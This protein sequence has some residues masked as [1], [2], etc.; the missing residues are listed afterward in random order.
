MSAAL[1]GAILAAGRGTR[2]GPFSERY[3]KPL[4]PVCN[5]PLIQH[6]IALMRS[7][8]VEEIFVL[9]GHRGY[10]IVRVLG[11]GSQLGVRIHY[12]EQS[13]M[14]GIAHAVGCLEPHLDRP[15]LLSL[16]DIFFV[17][18]DLGEMQ[19]LL[20][21]QGGGGVLA[22]RNETDPDAV[23]RNFTVQLSDDGYVRRVIEKPRHPTT[24][25][26]GV[27]LYLFDP[28]IFD[29]IRRTPRTALRDEYEL[30]ES[31]QVMIDDGRPVRV[32]HVVHEDINVTTPADLLRCNL[33]QARR[34]PRGMLVGRDTWIH[35][36]AQIVN[37]VIGSR[38]RIE[39]AV[40]IANSV[41]FDDCH[42][43]TETWL[44]TVVVTP[45]LVVECKHSLA[46]PS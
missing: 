3:P 33:D 39:K 45:D 43:N 22:V 5:V 40:K 41:V 10:K 2:M 32:A 36:D 13:A 21:E 11:D 17:P 15:F 7:V 25:I 37:S 42:V 23:R 24:R 8:G 26:K 35:P 16:G 27:G 19:R 44:D 14:L 6:Q 38:V 18:G 30:T 9:I 1:Q 31:I 12:V 4:L 34:N 28:S 29:A 46:S 20:E